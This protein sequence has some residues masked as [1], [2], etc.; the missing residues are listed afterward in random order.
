M[1][2]WLGAGLALALLWVALPDRVAD[3]AVAL[4]NAAALLGA[5]A[6]L[7]DVDLGQWD[8]DVLAPLA[9]DHLALRHIFAQILFDLAA[10]DLAE[11]I[12]VALG[13][14]DGHRLALF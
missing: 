9:A 4:A 3:V 2:P 1:L 7:R 11:A 12:E 13:A 8:R 6:E 10:Y 5:I 14:F